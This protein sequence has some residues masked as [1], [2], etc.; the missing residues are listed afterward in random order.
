MR[1]AQRG[2][3]AL[4]GLALFT[5]TIALNVVSGS[6]QVGSGTLTGMV[7][8][9]DRDVDLALI[10]RLPV[11]PAQAIEIRAEVFN[12]MNTPALGAPSA[13]LG[14]ASFGTITSAGDPRVVQLALKILF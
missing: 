5:V 14:A 4:A 2:L 8:D 10:R 6:A 11:G 3:A 12:L 9:Q 7:R 1:G 13:V